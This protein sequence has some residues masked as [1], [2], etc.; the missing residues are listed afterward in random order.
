MGGILSP[1]PL[2]FVDLLLYLQRLQ[3]VELWLMG[4]KLGVE[5]IFTCFLLL[6]VRLNAGAG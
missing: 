6:P 3:V 1:A 5:F 4:L 2:D